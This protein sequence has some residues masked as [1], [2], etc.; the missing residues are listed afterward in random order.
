MNM[1]L[2]NKN[3]FHYRFSKEK[4]LVDTDDGVVIAGWRVVGEVE[5]VEG[6]GGV[7]GNEKN[8]GIK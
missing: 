6:M 1:R 3:V 4:E 5:V 2:L 7:N 8:N